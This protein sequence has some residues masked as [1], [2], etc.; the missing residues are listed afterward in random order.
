M[1]KNPAILESIKLHVG[2]PLLLIRIILLILQWERGQGYQNDR[3]GKFYKA[4][5]SNPGSSKNCDL[6]EQ[7][8]KSNGRLTWET[9]RADPASK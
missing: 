8:N 3:D 7:K 4:V 9:F 5:G 1:L 6:H 2:N